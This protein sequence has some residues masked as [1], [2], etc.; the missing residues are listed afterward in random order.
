MA[1]SDGGGT[2][3]DPH[4]NFFFTIYP[5][6]ICAAGLSVWFCPFVYLHVYVH[7]YV[8]VHMYI[9]TTTIPTC[10]CYLCRDGC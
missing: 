5:V 6:H 10:Y 2:S 4:Y 8:Y 3:S 9:C 1:R 7:V